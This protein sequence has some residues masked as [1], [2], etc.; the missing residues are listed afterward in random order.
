MSRAVLI[1]NQG[2]GEILKIVGWEEAMTDWCTNTS[3]P[4]EYHEGVAIR[5]VDKEFK[6][7]SVMVQKHYSYVPYQRKFGFSAKNVFIRD[8]YQCCYCGVKL[9]HSQ[10]TIDHVFPTSK[11]GT[12][13]W[14]NCVTCCPRCNRKKGNKLLSELGWKMWYQP[15]KMTKYDFYAR[16]LEQPEYESWSKYIKV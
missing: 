10:A 4:I 16:Y 11:G 13:E 1:L 2:G 14:M 6:L 5:T 15:C 12:S 7:P 8:R 3:E 9:T